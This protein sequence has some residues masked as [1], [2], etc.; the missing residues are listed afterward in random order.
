MNYEA[1][2]AFVLSIVQ[3]INSQYLKNTDKILVVP[4]TLIVVSSDSEY[5]QRWDSHS[6]SIN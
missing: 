4:L 6:F 3:N 5:P 2:K 1:G